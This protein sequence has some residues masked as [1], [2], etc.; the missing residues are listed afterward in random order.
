MRVSCRRRAVGEGETTPHR[1]AA[2]WS[3]L[4]LIELCAQGGA[5]AVC[6][7]MVSALVRVRDSCT[8]MLTR[9][10]RRED[11]M[12]D[13]RV[14]SGRTRSREAILISLCKVFVCD[15]DDARVRARVW[16]REGR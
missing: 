5:R 2:L 9:R 6:A 3:A 15:G 11:A 4:L 10:A 1:Y 16:E 13:A 8:T 12:G 7:S 14:R